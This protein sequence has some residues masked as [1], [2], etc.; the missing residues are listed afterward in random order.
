MK[1]R[2]D[3]RKVFGI[4]ISFIIGL[5]ILGSDLVVSKVD[6]PLL[7]TSSLENYSSGWDVT[8][9]GIT[10]SEIK[11]PV[12][13]ENASI[14][15][16][17]IITKELPAQ[18]EKDTNIFFRSSHQNVKVYINE[19]KVYSFGWGE[20]RLFGKS[21]GCSWVVVPIRTDQA[22]ETVQIELTG[23]YNIYSGMIHS[24]Y[25]GDRSAVLH[26]IV[27]T[28]LGS[29][30]ACIVLI[31][32][33]C[34]MIIIALVLKNG[35]VTVSL[36][37][38]GILSLFV[39]VWSA[40]VTN[41]L[42]VITGNVF[43]LLNLEFFT[44]T[45]ML[46]IFLWF[47]YSFSYYRNRKIIDILFW[48]SVILFLGIE[49]LQLTSVA[50]Y[51]E[52]IIASHILIGFVLAY[53]GIT[54]I[55][56][57]IK[58]GAPREVKMLV[59]SVTLLLVSIGIDLARF[60]LVRSDDEGFYT[61]IGTLLFITLW[62][63]EIIRN[64]S[65][66]IVKMTRT[67]LLETLAYEDQMT[68]LKNRSAFEEKLKELRELKP[69]CD[70]FIIEF[71]MNNLKLINDNFG[72]SKGDMAIISI[73]NIIKEEFGEI[74]NC[75]RI[76]GDEICV[77]ISDC[78]DISE[79]DVIFRMDRIYEKVLQASKMLDLSFSVA[80]GYAKL[81]PGEAGNIDEAYKE[82]DKRMYE[83][84]QKMKSFR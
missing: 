6:K 37:R 19:K 8:L 77:I 15:E 42:Q 32:I 39:G 25:W 78:Q 69:V 81:S 60:Y 56:E 83:S 16:T 65:Q 43:M 9:N 36:F 54:G 48:M 30:L 76:G 67:K 44:F 29:I 58:K 71:D 47:L 11:L 50:D 64:M 40:C 45:L 18:I 82:A 3:R 1:L 28:R 21:P 59:A 17:I 52:S 13:V 63:I 20:E 46:P 23:T 80:G 55:W 5:I 26:E 66:I 2:K 61:R 7:S 10:Q 57:L 38:L 72:H 24:V 62:A 14:G 33:G 34:A 22:G 68:G 35:R 70:A 12:T 41:V 31:T 27:I 79:G 49:I 51:M 74:C 4:I 53:L 73:A 84:K 75:Y